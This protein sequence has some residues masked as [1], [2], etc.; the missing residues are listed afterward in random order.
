MLLLDG[1]LELGWV[2]VLLVYGC[3]YVSEVLVVV[4]GWGDC[5]FG[6][7]CVVCIILLENVVLICVVEKV[8]FFF[9]CDIIFYDVLI[10]MFMC[11]VLV[12]V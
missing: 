7:Y 1:M 11:D 3:G 4:F 10:C 8:G 9:W 6:V 12:M 2:F 5:Y